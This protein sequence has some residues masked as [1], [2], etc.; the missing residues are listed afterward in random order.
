VT[1]RWDNVE[2]IVH[3]ALERPVNER[4]TFLAA[5]CADDANLHADV[6]SLLAQEAAAEHLLNTPAAI[7]MTMGG[8][9]GTFVGRE[10]GTYTVVE[11]LGIGGMGEVYRAHD[12]QLDR[13][14][15]IKILPSV[16]TNNPDRLVRFE[17][18]AKILA[19]LNHPHV[20]AI[21][22]LEHVNGMPALILELVDGPTLSER[23]SEGAIAISVAISMATQIADALD[24]AHRRGIIHR[25]LKPAN[26]KVTATGS[27]KLLDFGLAKGIGQDNH[28]TAV[29]SSTSPP[30]MSRPGAIL[31]TAAYMSP[32]QARGEVVD[33]RSDLFSFG[34]VLYEMVTGRQA[35]GGETAS[36]ILRGI[37]NDT[38]SSPRA[39]NPAIPPALDDLVMRLLAKERD[40]RPQRAADVR[41]ELQRLA[42]ELESGPHPTLRRWLRRAAVAAAVILA[43]VASW[44]WRRPAPASTA[45]REYTQITHFADSA[46]SPALSSDGRL[47]TFI[48]G[49]STFNGRGHI[50][51]KAL[52][53][54]EPIQLTSDNLQKMSPVFSPDDQ[55][56]VYTVIK[57]PFV[58]DTWT[59]PVRGGNA[60][61]QWLGNASGLTWLPKGP[62]LFSEI[63]SG[64]HMQ[65]IAADEQ[66]NLMRL[67]YSPASE[68]GM[69]HRTDVSPDAA[70]A[71]VVEMDDG[72]W[73]PCRLVS[74]TGQ[75]PGRR[76]GPDGPC[77]SA[78]WSP[79]GRWM[80]FSSSATGTFH[81][82]R[83][84]FPDGKP[85]QLTFGATEEEGIAPD[86]DG[87]SLLTSV[88]TR[89]SSVWIRDTRGERESSREGFAFIP[90][91]P[92]GS[93][94]Q[95]LV[96]NGESVLYL[97]RQ[98]AMRSA[99]V[100]ERV[101]ELWATDVK[102]GARRAILQGRQ[103]IGF[104]VSRDGAQ[105]VFA[106]L[107][108]DGSSRVWLAR[109]NES[110]AARQLTNAEADSPRF[111]SNGNIF[112]RGIENG[113]HFVYRLREGHAPEKA[114][115]SPVLFFM[116][117]SP[118]GK[119]LIARIQSPNEQ[120]GNHFNAALPVAGG[121]PVRL[122][123]QCEV[124]WTPNGGHLLLRFGNR[125][126]ES[127][128]KTVI[129]PLEAGL[130]LPRWPAGGV[131][132]EAALHI[133]RNVRAVP[134]WI[135]PSEDLSTHVFTRCTTTRNI[136]RVPL[137]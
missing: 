117:T 104:D 20:G 118:D 121:P 136:Y 124:D 109:L 52:P 55:T 37:L 33:A 135:Y 22:G 98:G 11:L 102:T 28:D 80:Y 13:D 39:L 7:L 2:R 101:G 112:Y 132:S 8:D 96:L 89:R 41:N 65:V 108:N 24:V 64:L 26:I 87:R 3:G 134:R 51:V 72:T 18:E 63:T 95:P 94:S 5:A 77:T 42:R 115:Q 82:W 21:Y 119:W 12:R 131:D 58:W 56:I 43:A 129:V 73:L 92:T 32:E 137:S 126:Q 127:G 74:S 83:Q 53:D 34:A 45:E 59:V 4:A 76:V 107:N 44:L 25:D 38:P 48:R 86:P 54:G 40:A 16:F 93:A 100:A 123:D 71:L 99:G 49:P 50:Y 66:R 114:V 120:G 75:T 133:G 128:S 97:V 19:A 27:V 90:T 61:R 110:A 1:N 23:L 36:S 111:D 106:A 91:L 85:E 62:L 84:R 125:C 68:Q 14:V 67:V 6:Q 47:V 79:D 105:V 103:V 31:G 10:F 78:V 81:I 69:A 46:T 116:T 88:G 29:E 30:S 9:A 70:W 122:C 57:S 35:F 130:A 113:R 60:A 17:R 15:A